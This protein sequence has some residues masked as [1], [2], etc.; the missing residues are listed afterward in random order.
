M[1]DTRHT[2]EAFAEPGEPVGIGEAI[3]VHVDSQNRDE[4]ARPV[5]LGAQSRIDVDQAFSIVVQKHG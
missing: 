5:G 1:P 4:V 3:A 2:Y